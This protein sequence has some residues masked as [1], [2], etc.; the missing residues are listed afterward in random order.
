MLESTLVAA[1][2]LIHTTRRTVLQQHGDDR[3]REE[4][5]RVVDEK[6]GVDVRPDV[7]EEDGQ[8][9]IADWYHQMHDGV[10]GCLAYTRTPQHAR[11]HVFGNIQHGTSSHAAR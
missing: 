2:P 7:G 8:K 5:P 11:M 3:Q 4:Q 10:L 1:L 6:H 9:K